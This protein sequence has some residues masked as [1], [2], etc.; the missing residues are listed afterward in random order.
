MLCVPVQSKVDVSSVALNHHSVPVIVI[1][2]AAGGD[3]GVTQDG[4]IL[5]TAC[6][7]E[8]LYI[9]SCSTQCQHLAFPSLLN[10]FM[11]V[12]P[13]QIYLQQQ[14]RLA[15]LEG[16]VV[17]LLAFSM[18]DHTIALWGLEPQRYHVLDDLHLFHLHRRQRSRELCTRSQQSGRLI[19]CLKVYE[20]VGS[21]KLSS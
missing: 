19:I 1:Q 11:L 15:Q 2:E 18:E 9:R 20:R 4:A 17:S 13:T 12:W 6:N 3:G 16:D 14:L 10:Q 5:V 21:V 7:E 8:Q